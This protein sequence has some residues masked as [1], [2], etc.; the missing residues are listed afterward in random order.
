MSISSALNFYAKIEVRLL[1]FPL[2]PLI[3]FHRDVF[4]SFFSDLK[5]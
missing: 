1:H 2:L 3:T 4:G 5:R